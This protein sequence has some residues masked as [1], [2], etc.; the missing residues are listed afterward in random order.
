MV[1]PAL[2]R[3]AV[4]HLL[5]KGFSRVCA[6]R[7]VSLS[8]TTSRYARKERNPELVASIQKLANKHPRYGFHRIH[9]KLVGVNI[10]AVRRIWIQFGLK[11]NRK[12]RKRLKVQKPLNCTITRPNQAWCMDFIHDRLE[13]GRQVRIFGV[14][15]CFTRE[16]LHLR[17]APSFPSTEVTKDL[18]FLFLVHGTP[19]TIISDNGPEFRALTLPDGVTSGFIQPGKPWQNGYIESFNGKLRDEALNFQVFSTG[20]QMQQHLWE[21]QDDYNNHR[22]HRGIHGLTPAQFKAGLTTSKMEAILQV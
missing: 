2:R 9:L 1:S 4:H 21:F 12:P 18:E 20:K 8:R 10:K 13:N 19:E 17:A 22:P 6:C 14:L 5:V 3:G 11:L 15:D 16:C 7:V